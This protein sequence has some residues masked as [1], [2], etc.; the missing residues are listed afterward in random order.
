MSPSS[1]LVGVWRRVKIHGFSVIPGHKTNTRHT[2][3]IILVTWETW[4]TVCDLGY[5]PPLGPLDK[6]VLIYV[7]KKKSV[8]F[9]F[10]FN[11]MNL[12]MS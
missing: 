1:L 7:L 5:V 10:Q 6:R 11:V 3:V 12:V 4:K 8:I 9:L 2:V